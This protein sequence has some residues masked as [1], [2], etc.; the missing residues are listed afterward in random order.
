MINNPGLNKT[1]NIITG[2]LAL[3][4]HLTRT[5]LKFRILPAIPCHKLD[6]YCIS[7]SKNDVKCVRKGVISK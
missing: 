5:K 7:I 1:L 6:N 2:A 3:T 4:F